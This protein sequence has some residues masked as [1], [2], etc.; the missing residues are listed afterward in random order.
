MLDS[1]IESNVMGQYEISCT[2]LKRWEQVNYSIDFQQH[3]TKLLIFGF[4]KCW[5]KIKTWCSSF[6]VYQGIHNAAN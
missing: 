4:C 1:I 5:R 6:F 2:L 3:L